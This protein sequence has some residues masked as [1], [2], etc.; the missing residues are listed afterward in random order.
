MIYFNLIM[1][2]RVYVI[3][4]SE[5]KHDVQSR[6]TFLVNGRRIFMGKT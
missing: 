2:Y 1:I 5:H 6:S 4:Y 3:A